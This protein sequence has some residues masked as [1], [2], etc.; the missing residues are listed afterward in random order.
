MVHETRAL[1]LLALLVGIVL[2]AISGLM[3]EAGIFLLLFLAGGAMFRRCESS[4]RTRKR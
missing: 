1:V 4:T 3:F 2:F